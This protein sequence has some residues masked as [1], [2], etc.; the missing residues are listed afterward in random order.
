[1]TQSP[2]SL[3]L[4]QRAGLP[5]ALR[6]LAEAYP[7]ADWSDHPNFGEMIRFWIDRHMMFR[8]L[9]LVLRQD[10][11]KFLDGGMEFEHYAPRLSHYGGTLLNQL[12][13]HHQIEDAHYFPQLIQLDKRLE[14]GFD[15][16]ETDH[17]AMDGLLHGMANGANAVLGEGAEKAGAFLELLTDFENLLER[18]LYDEEDIVVPVVLHTGFSG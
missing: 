8:Q 15:L 10:A 2:P 3:A 1:M 13:G 7:R 14:R 9:T 6:V 5:E 17:S 12:H 4:D 18:H 16:L 11:Q